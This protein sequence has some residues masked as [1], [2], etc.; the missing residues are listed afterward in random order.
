LPSF[1]QKATRENR[2]KKKKKKK[3]LPRM[4]LKMPESRLL[5]FDLA[6][7]LFFFLSASDDIVPSF[8]LRFF[9]SLL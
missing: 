3:K 9:F 4:D 6:I 5:E 2:R 8:S 7:R 1:L